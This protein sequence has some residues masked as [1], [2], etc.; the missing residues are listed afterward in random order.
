MSPPCRDF[1][2]RHE[3]M[4]LLIGPKWRTL[5]QTI[6]QK[7]IST[8]PLSPFLSLDFMKLKIKN[9]HLSSTLPNTNKIAISA[10]FINLDSWFNIKTFC[11]MQIHIFVK[12]FW[13]LGS[14]MASPMYVGLH[15][16]FKQKHLQW[17]EPFIKNRINLMAIKLLLRPKVHHAHNSKVDRS[18][19]TCKAK[20]SSQLGCN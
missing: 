8:C 9:M 3:V 18:I 17:Q 20:R 19:F 4:A 10:T 6:W 5:V 1:S 12:G 11:P 15:C 13:S 2:S 14:S 7:Y 16:Q